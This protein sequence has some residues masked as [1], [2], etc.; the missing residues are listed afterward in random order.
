MCRASRLGK[1]ERLVL[2]RG[3]VYETPAE[4]PY[5]F[6]F[7]S[8]SPFSFHEQVVGGEVVSEHRARWPGFGPV[9]AE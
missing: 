3:L 8:L 9:G 7:H 4:E 5:F 2:Y 6:L 1:P